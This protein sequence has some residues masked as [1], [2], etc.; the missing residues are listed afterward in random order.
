MNSRG[1]RMTD[2]RPTIGAQDLRWTSRNDTPGELSVK[3][4]VDKRRSPGRPLREGGQRILSHNVLLYI[5]TL[6]IG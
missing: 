1:R 5:S 4:C 3:C 6:N 2:N